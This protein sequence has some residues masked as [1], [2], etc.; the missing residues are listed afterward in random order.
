MQFLGLKSKKN[1]LVFILKKKQ[2]EQQPKAFYNVYLN[3]HKGFFFYILSRNGIHL[4][5]GTLL[6]DLQ[7]NK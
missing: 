1:I 4:C 6:K 7:Q 3:F 5:A 2:Q